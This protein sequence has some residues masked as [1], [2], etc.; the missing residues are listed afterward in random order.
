M[1]APLKVIVMCEESGII[2][3]AFAAR[4]HDAW[5]CDIQPSERGGKHIQDDARKHLN[6][7]WDLM[8]AH[9][10]CTRLCNS[11]VRWLSERN[12]WK[13]L[14]RAVEF[15][16]C[17]MN[18]PVPKRAIE[19]P[20]PHKYAIQKIG[21]KY[22]QIIQPWQFG[23]GETKKTCLWLFR[24]PPLFHTKLVPGRVARVHLEPPGENRSKNRS[25]TYQG[26]ANA[27]AEQWG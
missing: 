16:L 9:P 6:D 10:V 24:L 15:F 2:R 21:R 3:D 1:E 17:F 8:I 27:M 20:V 13:E 7:G 14:D 11:G 4:G 5:S 22:D 23:E 25:R 12:L 18:A 19:N 26:I